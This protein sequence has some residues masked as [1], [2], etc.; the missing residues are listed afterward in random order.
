VARKSVQILLSLI[1]L[2]ASALSAFAEPRKQVILQA[3]W[4]EGR[5]GGGIGPGYRNDNYPLGWFNYLADLAPR[6]RQ[7]G[8]DAVWIPPTVKNA[9]GA[10]CL[11]EDPTTN[12]SKCIKGLVPVLPSAAFGYA[13][14]D[15]YDLG[16]KYQ[17]GSLRTKLGTKDEYLRM[18]AVMHANGINIIQ[19]VVFNQLTAAGSATPESFAPGTTS[20]KLEDFRG[21]R[22]DGA[23]VASRGDNQYKNFRYVSFST[24]AINESA[25]NYLARN[26]RWP[27]NWQNFHPNHG[28]V[29]AGQSDLSSREC[30]NGEV[31]GPNFGRDV[32]YNE[33]AFGQSSTPGIFDPVQ[34]TNYM[35]TEAARWLLWM[36]NQ[37]GVDGFRWD[38]AKHFDAIT[39]SANADHGTVAAVMEPFGANPDMISVAEVVDSAGNEDAWTNMANTDAGTDV[40]GT[41][42]FPLRG[43]LR[44]MVLTFG[45][46]DMQSIPGTQQQDRS[47]TVPFINNHDTFR[48]IL[49]AS[50][51]YGA[52]G[53]ASRWDNG[54]ELGGGHIDPREERLSG[55]YAI[56]FAVDGSPQVF[57]EDLFDVGTTGKRFT[58]LQG[59]E[60]DLPVNADLV[61]IIWCHRN[62]RF[63]DG[64]YKVKTA[65]AEGPIWP[66]GQDPKD[67]LVIERS[68]RA[69]IGVNHNHD[70]WRAVTIRTDFPP[71][72]R[73]HDYSGVNS[74]DITV[75]GDQRVT[76][77][78]PPAKGDGAVKRKGYTIW[79]S[80]GINGSLNAP[81]PITQAWEMANDLGDSHPNSLRE[82]G[83]LAAADQ[84]THYVGQ[85][86]TPGS[87]AVAVRVAPEYETKRYR[88]TVRNVASNLVFD[89]GAVSG[90]R[91]FNF[92]APGGGE[93]RLRIFLKSACPTSGNGGDPKCTAPR[94]TEPTK[95]RASVTY[96]GSV[97]A[98]TMANP[99]GPNTVVNAG[100]PVTI[101]SGTRGSDRFYYVEVPPGAT[102]VQFAIEP[103]AGASGDADLLIKFGAQATRVSFDRKSDTAAS[104]SES[105]TV[106]SPQPGGWYISVLGASDYT[107]VKLMVTVTAG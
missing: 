101:D 10:A 86:Q 6:L 94:S 9:V 62:L 28:H 100:T 89:S 27:R 68:Q 75:P 15:F 26:G 90:T 70:T 91:L 39:A 88:L 67:L 97:I 50:G 85:I 25:A 95:M 77:W 37:T 48:P 16:D 56:A 14:F 72:T 99:M 4:W 53:D 34:A 36:K 79:G 44:D 80:A 18:V 38:A 84:G 21:G 82:G 22:D 13:P 58:H 69:I 59:S 2:G 92:N 106:A 57:F 55:A 24:P 102:S 104:S 20:D 71:G 43:K 49:D 81:M 54:S 51:N 8:I 64:A 11:G 105:I 96:D 12:P 76:M 107:R 87:L 17:K 63:K 29:D 31:C 35:R 33:A 60:A 47:R 30:D 3:F 19:D 5:P 65:D 61:N 66:D 98:A 41:F 45:S 7:I 74:D 1:L 52:L 103:L 32:C 23:H 46:F 73:L 78:A 93:Q 42:D 83:G 40:V